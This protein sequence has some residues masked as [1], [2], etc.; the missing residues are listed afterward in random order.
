MWITTTNVIIFGGFFHSDQ[1]DYMVKYTSFIPHLFY[2]DPH[3]SHSSLFG[4][5]ATHIR[6]MSQF[7]DKWNEQC[8]NDLKYYKIKSTPCDMWAVLV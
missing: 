7:W 5:T 4:A 3:I 8:W 1:E 6:I 2:L